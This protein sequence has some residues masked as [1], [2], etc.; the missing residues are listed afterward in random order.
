MSIFGSISKL[1]EKTPLVD[2]EV[3][4]LSS[5]GA[6]EVTL[7]DS[8]FY[9]DNGDGTVTD[10]R[11]GLMWM[12]CAEGQKLEEG[13]VTGVAGTFTW[14]HAIGLRL[15]FAGFN[16]WELP[17]IESLKS[18]VESN[19]MNPAINSSV[20]P[21]TPCFSFWS[22]ST[23]KRSGTAQMV[24][25]SEGFSDSISSIKK[26]HVR[27][28]R[29]L[30][31][32]ALKRSLSK[33]LV[34]CTVPRGDL[35]NFVHKNRGLINGGLFDNGRT[36]LHLAAQAG[37]LQI[38]EWLLQKGAEA[39]AIDWHGAT[40]FDLATAAGA[41]GT[42]DYLKSQLSAQ[43]T[44][45]QVETDPESTLQIQHAPITTHAADG[46]AGTTIESAT[47][48]TWFGSGFDYLLR[49][50]ENTD[51]PSA[52]LMKALAKQNLLV[53]R[54]GGARN[55]T[56]LHH[57]AAHGKLETVKYL[58]LRCRADLNATDQDG[59][60]PLDYAL[61]SNAVGVA[62]Y[63]RLKEARTRAD[64]S[65]PAPNHV[66]IDKA[67]AERRMNEA[68][69]VEPTELAQAT[70]PAPGLVDD[71]FRAATIDCSSVTAEL[72]QR[73]ELLETSLREVLLKLEILEARQVVASEPDNTVDDREAIAETSPGISV[74]LATY[75]RVSLAVFRDR[76]LPLDLL[77]CAVIDELNERALD[78]TGE[79]ALEESGEEIL[80]FREV[81]AT[82]IANQKQTP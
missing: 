75:D 18:I 2:G 24:H 43:E 48:T 27:F 17:D 15:S 64:L 34:E 49:D 37:K 32:E 62:D 52:S 3:L 23:G 11:T 58:C 35:V 72:T 56:L 79:I 61:A 69:P 33:T 54:V 21:L 44:L 39:N 82:V 50:I 71:V 47:G 25:F 36:M 67:E 29:N 9:I 57:A 16:D 38:V 1:F 8:S 41:A 26:C 10:K 45:V 20:F 51:K 65:A 73:V 30:L 6:E 22:N 42:A 53:S 76:L 14:N 13:I 78:L 5:S 4:P 74:W 60:T 66:Q 46:S 31:P 59:H 55:R 80:V 28:V 19:R 81:L 12:R 63:L 77:P 68:D 40:P 70:T 7:A